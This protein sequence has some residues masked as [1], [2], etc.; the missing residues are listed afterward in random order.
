MRTRTTRGSIAD[1]GKVL[2]ANAPRWQ[3]IENK[4]HPLILCILSARDTPV[5]VC[6]PDLCAGF[7]AEGSAAAALTAKF[8][9]GVNDGKLLHLISGLRQI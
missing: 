1:N 5:V 3:V 7:T 6:L 8:A 9:L 2:H 4:L